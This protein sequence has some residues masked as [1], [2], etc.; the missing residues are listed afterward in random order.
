MVRSGRHGHFHWLVGPSSIPSLVELTVRFHLGLRLCITAFD[1]GPI[2][3]SSEDQVEG[4]MAR[5]AATVSPPLAEGLNIPHDQYDE[6]YLLNEPPS[7]EWQPEIFVNIGGFTLVTTEE[8]YKSY[9]PTWDRHGLDWLDP[10]QERFWE[11]LERL[12]PVSY[13]AMGEQIIV[14]S[15]RREFVEQ[16][17]KDAGTR[18]ED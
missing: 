17:K 1:G 4:W 5:E 7:F 10:I 8:L 14:V 16:L 12:N 15:R 13:I 3:P 6:W 9:D 18:A 2:R 11:Q